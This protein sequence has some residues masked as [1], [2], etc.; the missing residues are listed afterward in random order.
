MKRFL[1]VL[2]LFGCQQVVPVPEPTPIPEPTVEPT[3]T[4][5]PTPEPTL[6]ISEDLKKIIALIEGE[7]V[8]KQKYIPR[9]VL[10]TK[11][12][13]K[14]KG[15]SQSIKRDVRASISTTSKVV[16]LRSIE[17]SVKDQGQ[18]GLCT[19]FA[20]SAGM[21]ML[22][23]SNLD[24]SEKHLWSKYQQ[25][26]TTYALFASKKYLITSENAWPY[27]LNKPLKRVRGVAKTDTYG[28][29]L[30][31]DD[32]YKSLDEGKAVVLSAETNTSW[33]NPYMGVLRTTGTKQG[34][35]AIKVSG[36]F[37]T[38]RGRYLI[39]KNSWGIAYGHKGYVYL[40]ETYCDRHWCAFHVIS[41]VNVAK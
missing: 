27:N 1:L 19:A 38:S 30:A 10:S 6:T 26:D 36:Y 25:Y 15:K 33:S 8:K 40:P 29:L 7:S 23:R 5:T 35:H 21:E 2:F 20:V 28:E 12:T 11:D 4:Q 16:D 13:K 34:G 39:I 22:A 24:L 3:P 31:W 18:E 17:T 41:Q 32:V 9:P 37:D 14:L